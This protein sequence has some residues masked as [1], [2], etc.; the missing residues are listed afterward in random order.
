M[1]LDRGGFPRGGELCSGSD[2]GA[3]GAGDCGGV[4]RDECGHGGDDIGIRG[5][6]VEEEEGEDGE[7][8]EKRRVR[9]RG[10]GEA[11]FAELCGDVYGVVVV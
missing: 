5:V 9:V 6:V 8:V 11:G 3:R 10:G 1:L 2:D 7:V 4:G